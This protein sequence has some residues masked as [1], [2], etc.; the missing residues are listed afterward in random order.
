MIY[1]F[2]YIG[3]SMEI[4]RDCLLKDLLEDLGYLSSVIIDIV[5]V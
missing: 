4:E 5:Y 1:Y 2:R 3:V